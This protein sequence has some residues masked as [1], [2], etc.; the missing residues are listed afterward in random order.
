MEIGI[1]Q[2]TIDRL[3]SQV[4]SVKFLRLVRDQVVEFL[5]DNK[6]IRN[7]QHGFRKGIVRV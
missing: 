6:L 7:S 3:V 2:L 1:L 5:E 4:K